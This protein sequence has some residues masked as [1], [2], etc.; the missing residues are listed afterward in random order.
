[1]SKFTNDPADDLRRWQ[2][3]IF[4]SVWITY[5]AYY[6]CRYN[7]P[8]AKSRLCDTFSWDEA[9]FGM[10]LSSLLLMY[11]V[12]QFV[13]GQLADRFGTRIIASLGVLGS[14]V[15]N[16]LVFA[17]VVMAPN[18]DVSTEAI[19]RLLVI[20]WGINGFFQAMGWTPMVRAM[21]H[22]FPTSSRGKVMGLMGTCYQFG[23]AF[24]WF[25]AYFV[26][27][28]YAKELGGDWRVVFLVP[29]VLFA[30]VGVFFFVLIRNCPEDVGQPAVEVEDGSDKDPSTELRRTIRHNIVKTLKNPYLWVVA[31]TFF[32]LDLNRYGFV[33]WLPAF[34]DESE[35]SMDVAG[36]GFKTVMKR[37]IHP[38]SGSAG[39][40]V[41]GWATDRFFKGRRAPVI[42]LLLLILGIF[43]IIFPYIDPTNTWLVMSVI[44]LIGFCT[45]GP[46][47][48]MVG[49]AAQD[50]GKK[51]GAAGAAGFI[52]GMGYIGAALAGWG[53]GLI[54]VKYGY[55]VDFVTFGLAAILGAL[56]VCFIWK[57]G[58]KTHAKD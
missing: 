38:L 31:L 47:I 48:L 39:A 42:A 34:L 26:I 12:G 36:F 2:V 7:M 44:A 8:M 22:W 54:I 28:Y 27:E 32:L 19:F 41:A 49:H 10:I 58:P 40:V 9:Q 46:H 14:V 33:N 4:S 50:F 30:V 18:R 13:N 29:A 16:L 45:Y 11:A 6:L 5:F 53:A 15:M 52:D 1:M 55:K 51:A 57:A 21:A 3:R 56:L 43:S 24:S 23:A 25:L 20:F 35:V 37:C 17:V